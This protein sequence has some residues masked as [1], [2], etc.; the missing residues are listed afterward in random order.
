[1]KTKSKNNKTSTMKMT[2]KVKT[3]SKTKKTPKMKMLLKMQTAYDKDIKKEK[4]DFFI[5]F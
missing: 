2:S 5:S 4:H 1:M 3:T